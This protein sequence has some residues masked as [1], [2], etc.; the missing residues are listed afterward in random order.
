MRVKFMILAIAAS[1][2]LAAT[3]ASV[4]VGG[5]GSAG[6]DKSATS[7][8]STGAGVSIGAGAEGSG[9]IGKKESESS[10][11]ADAVESRRSVDIRERGAAKGDVK[12]KP[13]RDLKTPRPPRE[14]S[15]PGSA[16]GSMEGSGTIR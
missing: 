3:G 1:F 6:V 8:D 14:V 11:S 2:P 9:T 12:V 13:Q 7:S 5:G 4:G 10:P 15:V 16:P